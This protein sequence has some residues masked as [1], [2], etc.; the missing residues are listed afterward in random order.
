[1]WHPRVVRDAIAQV[2]TAALAAVHSQTQPGSG[3]AT[4][5][6]ACS[7]ACWAGGGLTP[8]AK[9]W[10]MAHGQW[11]DTGRKPMMGLRRV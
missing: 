5:T 6:L 4:P 7:C 10:Q 9:R 8:G 3:A 1:M 11:A 2:E